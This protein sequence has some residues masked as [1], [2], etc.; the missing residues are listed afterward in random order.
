[1][2]L[3]KAETKTVAVTTAEWGIPV[4]ERM[5]GFTIMIYEVVKN[6]VIAASN[7]IFMV[8]LCAGRLNVLFI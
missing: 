6:V 3:P 7:S 5:I 2:I 1:M 8:V 4:C